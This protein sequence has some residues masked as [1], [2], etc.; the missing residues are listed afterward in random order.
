MQERN[1]NYIPETMFSGINNEPDPSEIFI[2]K[3][4]WMDLMAENH[5]ALC[6]S[7]K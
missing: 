1:N 4:C 5:L 6:V 3:S 2:I 7:F